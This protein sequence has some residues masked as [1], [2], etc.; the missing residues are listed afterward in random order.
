MQGMDAYVSAEGTI[1]EVRRAWIKV[2]LPCK[3]SDALEGAG[4]GATWRMDRYSPD[5]TYQR[6]IKVGK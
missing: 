6:Q 3:A 5:T 4:G 2:A 1:L